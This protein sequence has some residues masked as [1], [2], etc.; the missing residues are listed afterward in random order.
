MHRIKVVTNVSDPPKLTAV[1]VVRIEEESR[2]LQE[3]FA[4]RT[5]SMELITAA[6]LAT[7][8]R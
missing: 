2:R 1:E 4:A 7:R 8:I 3:A 5:A 6:D